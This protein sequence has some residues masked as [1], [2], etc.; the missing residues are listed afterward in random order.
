MPLSTLSAPDISLHLA[1]R[2]LTEAHGL[3]VFPVYEP[4]GHGCACA[5]G[6]R[7]KHPAKHPRTE[8]GFRDASPDVARIDAWWL[9]WPSAN[10]GVATGAVSGVV[11]LDVD[12]EAGHASLAT[13]T[14]LPDTWRSRTGRGEHVW[15]AHPGRPVGNRA[16]FMP[17]LDLRGDGGYVLAPPSRHASGATYGWL[18]GPSDVELAPVPDWL[19]E[20]VQAPEVRA[21][22]PAS[23]CWDEG[24]RN[25]RLWRLARSLHA[26][27][28]DPRLV[29]QV[30]QGVNARHCVPPLPAPE[31]A[32]ILRRAPVAEHREDFV[33]TEPIAPTPVK[34][35]G[36][37]A[38][39]FLR[40]T[41]PPVR[42]LVEGVLNDD[43]SGWIGGEEKLGKTFFALEEAL[44]LALGLPVCGRFPV[45]AVAPVLFVEEEDSARRTQNRIAALLRGHGLDPTDP[46]LLARL[47]ATFSLSVWAGFSFDVPAQLAALEARI[48]QHRPQVVYVDVLRK[49]TALDLNK[50]DQAA[51]L[52][53]ELDR[54]RRAYGCV[55]RV[56]HHFRKS[57][58]FRSGRGSQE[59]GGSY[60][61][62]AWAE[63]S[64][65][66]E[67]TSRKSGAPAAID[68]QLKDGAPLPRFQM[69][70]VEEGT[71]VRLVMDEVG[72]ERTDATERVFEALATLGPCDE[73]RDGHPGASVASLVTRLKCSE[74]T[75][76][77]ALKAL[78]DDGRANVVGH[79]AKGKA[80]WGLVTAA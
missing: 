50:Q 30:V 56:I 2:D 49:V 46:A 33:G 78:K 80:L 61:L 73:P 67:P 20:L 45:P 57:Q 38:G 63:N 54:L 74:V 47:D 26:Q 58:G 70:I 13:L 27:G 52:L 62:G 28:L 10:I 15:F 43:G 31:I 68:I 21:P 41:Y 36:L 7:C 44:C 53:G 17:G 3:R 40:T 24:T 51:R 66:F 22:V 59:I 55:F 75:I 64:I 18:V 79:A 16:G 6:A 39:A 35:L 42:P 34:P 4:N 77:R 11:V 9:D 32:D 8:H 72:G 71:A 76:R 19:L 5:D 65:F 48:R 12:G 1:A 60:V 14:P 69:R 23:E 37:G 29:D 25:D